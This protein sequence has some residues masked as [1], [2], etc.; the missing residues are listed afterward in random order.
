MSKIK[1]AGKH[2]LLKRRF[3]IVV[4]GIITLFLLTFFIKDVSAGASQH[5]IPFY[6]SLQEYQSISGNDTDFRPLLAGLD[7]VE[8]RFGML[9]VFV[10]CDHND[11]SRFYVLS[12]VSDTSKFRQF[13][14]SSENNKWLADNRLARKGQSSL[15]HVLDGMEDT[16]AGRGLL[17]NI[18]TVKDYDQFRDTFFADQYVNERLW[19]GIR[20]F[21]IFRSA[22]NKHKVY[23]FSTFY[24]KDLAE[25]YFDSEAYSSFCQHSGVKEPPVSQ[26]GILPGTQSRSSVEHCGGKDKTVYIKVN[27]YCTYSIDGKNKQRAEPGQIYVTCLQAGKHAVRFEDPDDPACFTTRELEIN[28]Q[29]ASVTHLNVDFRTTIKEKK[30]LSAYQPAKESAGKDIYA[31]D[32]VKVDGGSFIMGGE[33]GAGA[34]PAHSVALKSYYIGKYEVTQRLW[35]QVTGE[36]PAHF[37]GCEDC[38]VENVSFEDCERF[39]EKLNQLTGKKYRMPTEAEWEYAA[40]GGNQSRSYSYSGSSTMNEVAWNGYNSDYFTHP[41]GTKKP[42]EL[43]IYDMTG[44]VFEW[45]SDWFGPYKEG[46]VSNPQGPGTGHLKILRG[47]SWASDETEADVSNRVR[48]ITTNRGRRTGLRLAQDAE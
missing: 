2:R 36:N 24:S 25:D 34:L 19:S 46:H 7:T 4:R 23:V 14:H 12:G 20:Y 6:F 3:T 5:L 38:P 21:T 22:E 29:T 47:G 32:L 44:N 17:L 26:F 9:P 16:T 1:R 28:S 48:D 43:G 42:N 31:Y 15:L 39:I 13:E 41:V 27:H 11:C 33:N 8:S 45:C 10:F 40:R 37:R 35:K 18:F 30:L